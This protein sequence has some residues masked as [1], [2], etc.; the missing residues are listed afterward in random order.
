[1]LNG[2]EGI[3]PHFLVGANAIINRI[4]QL[5]SSMGLVLKL[6]PMQMPSPVT[7]CLA[8]FTILDVK[9]FTEDVVDSV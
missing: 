1:M 8:D 5:V 2:G 9:Q 3:V 4:D 7:A 6:S